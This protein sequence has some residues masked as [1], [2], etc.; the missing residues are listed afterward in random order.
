EEQQAFARQRVARAADGEADAVGNTGAGTQDYLSQRKG[1]HS[2]DRMVKWRGQ[3]AAPAAS[4]ADPLK[5]ASLNDLCRRVPLKPPR[6]QRLIQVKADGSVEGGRC[7]AVHGSHAHGRLTFTARR[8]I[9][10]DV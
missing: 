10:T 3:C 6:R 4:L 1:S 5:I 8:G 7:G 2:I 9:A